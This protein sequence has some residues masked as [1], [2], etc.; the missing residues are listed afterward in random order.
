MKRIS[1]SFGT[2]S[3]KHSNLAL[4][5]DMIDGVVRPKIPYEIY[6]RI[7]ERNEVIAAIVGRTVDDVLSNGWSW[8]GDVDVAEEWWNDNNRKYPGVWRDVVRDYILYGMAGVELIGV[9]DS[10]KW[11]ENLGMDVW[12]R[13]GAIINVISVDWGSF[14]IRLNGKGTNPPDPPEP[15]YIQNERTGFTIRKIFVMP[16]IG[17]RVYQDSPLQPL[18][19]VV[20]KQMKLLDYVGDVFSGRIPKQLMMAG[21]IEP[22]E[23]TDVID[24]V[25]KQ[26]KGSDESFGIM[27]VN[28]GKDQANVVPLTQTPSEGQF[29]GT[30]Y[31]YREEICAMFGIPP[32]KMGW[33]Q[34]GKLA[35]PEQQLD[36]W[37]DRVESIHHELELFINRINE[38]IGIN[39]VVKFNSIRPKKEK[40]KAETLIRQAGAAK[41]LVES[42]VM[43]VDE[44]RSSILELDNQAKQVKQVGD[45]DFF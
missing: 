24:A 13:T 30:L 12:D 19:G 33:V 44:V 16:G 3:N 35:N 1:K 21:D 27:A 37:Y 25:K 4:K 18:L 6:E 36:A 9:N 40:D 14:L 39:A 15:A 45:W 11:N 34:T 41:M 20:A 5:M 43:S 2:N 32:I 28:L 22:E 29:L 17:S 38:E 42:G 8:E 7:F 23:L 10:K 26:I 31:Y